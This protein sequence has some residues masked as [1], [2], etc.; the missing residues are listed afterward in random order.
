MENLLKFDNF[1]HHQKTITGNSNSRTPTCRLCF[2]EAKDNIDIF[3]QVGLLY[4]CDKK[5]QK[6]LY[7]Q[8]SY[9]FHQL[10]FWVGDSNWIR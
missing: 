7:L 10:A 8:V 3:S 6:Y 2:N 9:L 5:I 4:E 1:I